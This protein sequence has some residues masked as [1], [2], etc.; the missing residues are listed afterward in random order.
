[1]RSVGDVLAIVDGRHAGRV[2]ARAVGLAECGRGRL[3]VVARS[4]QERGLLGGSLACPQLYMLWSERHAVRFAFAQQAVR[5]VPVDVPVTTLCCDGSVRVL[6]SDLL[7]QRCFD[8]AVLADRRCGKW[9]RRRG[10]EPVL[11]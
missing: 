3:I 11:I 1:M 6:L 5:G 7:E 2:I 10:V 9:L 4:A 8:A